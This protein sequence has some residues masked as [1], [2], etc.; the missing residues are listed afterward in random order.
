[1]TFTTYKLNFGNV[2]CNNISVEIKNELF[3]DKL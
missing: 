1:M 3:T 2:C